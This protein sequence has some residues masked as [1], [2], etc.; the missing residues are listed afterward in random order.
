M[1]G[2]IVLLSIMTFF[3]PLSTIVPIHGAVQL[4]SNVSRSWFLKENIDWRIFRPFAVGLPIGGLIA[5]YIIKSIDNKDQFL[6]LIACLILYTI[7]KPKKLPHFQIPHWC[8]SFVGLIVGILS[9]LIGA[10]GPFI[11]IFFMRD[12]L[13]KKQVVATKASVQMVGHT[14]KI[15]IFLYTGFN[16]L[17]YSLPIVLLALGAILGTKFG[18]RILHGISEKFFKILFKTALL[19]A[20]I[21]IFY[22]VLS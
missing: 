20:A 17:E 21:R 6:V 3:L 18:V 11:A 4:T 8:F 19:G 15:P 7:F 5:T 22:K 9:P 12:D 10:T 14:I 1:A 16:Y 2:G 13:D